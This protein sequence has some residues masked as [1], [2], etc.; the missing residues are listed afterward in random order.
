MGLVFIIFI[1]FFKTLTQKLL[2]QNL[3]TSAIYFLKGVL[4]QG[5]LASV[6]KLLT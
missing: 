1:L 4:L 2:T 3:L 5:F 6:W